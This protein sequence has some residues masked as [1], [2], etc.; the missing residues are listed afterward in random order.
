MLKDTIGSV[1]TVR[2]KVALCWVQN[3]YPAFRVWDRAY[4]AVVLESE[5]TGHPVAMIITVRDERDI[6]LERDGLPRDWDG[7]TRT[8]SNVFADKPFRGRTYFRSAP[9]QVGKKLRKLGGFTHHSSSR[10]PSGSRWA[11]RVG[12]VIPHNLEPLPDGGPFDPASQNALHV[13]RED[14]WWR[15]IVTAKDSGR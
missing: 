10:S 9:V 15:A 2:G 7:D 14:S 13:L 5:Y 11:R 1:A 6:P 4:A 3:P 12:G 8:I